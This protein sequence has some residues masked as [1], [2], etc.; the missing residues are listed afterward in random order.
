M[1]VRWLVLLSFKVLITSNSQSC[2]PFQGQLL[3]NLVKGGIIFNP[4]V[5][6]QCHVSRDERG[7]D[8]PCIN[9]LFVGQIEDSIQFLYF[10]NFS[11]LIY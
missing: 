2:F 9:F 7:F 3:Q 10:N 6:Q 4:W 5:H 8:S 1:N 11:L